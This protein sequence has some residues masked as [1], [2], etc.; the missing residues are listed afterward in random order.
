VQQTHAH[1]AWLDVWLQVGIVGLVIFAALVLSALAR[2]WSLAVDRAQVAPGEPQPYTAVSLL[3]VLLLT[4]LIVQS[5][6]ESRLL[7]E[8]GWTMLV[9]IAVKTK[10]EELS[11]TRTG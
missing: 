2:S 10:A 3:P 6:A 7:V 11:R 9:L 8:F 4:A 1:N 5:L